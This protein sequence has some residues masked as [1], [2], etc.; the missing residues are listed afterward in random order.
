MTAAP[1][2]EP[3]VAR[4]FAGQDRRP[5][6]LADV[7]PDT[8]TA[9]HRCLLV[10]DG[11][12][13][14]MIE[15]LAQEPVVVDCLAQQEILLADPDGCGWLQVRPG[16]AVVRRRVVIRGASSGIAYAQAESDLVARRL[17]PG[18]VDLLDG[19]P[20]GL[21]AALATGQVESRNE[22]LWFGLA[23]GE[24]AP[25]EAAGQPALVRSYRVFVGG[26]PTL[27]VTQSFPC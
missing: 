19:E 16:T 17:P 23:A 11:I 8:L 22:L 10:T 21:G 25:E 15:A 5:A 20:G 3:L 2:A 9:Y 1:P 4:H 7:A 18:F 24:A 14:S 27:L 6:R 13:S 26:R 12:V